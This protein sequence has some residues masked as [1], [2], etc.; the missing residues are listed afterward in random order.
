MEVWIGDDSDLKRVTGPGRKA[1]QTVALN[2]SQGKASGQVTAVRI[3]PDGGRVALVLTAA[4]SSQIYI[5]NIV[6][7][8]NQVSVNGLT[9]ISPQGVAVTDV[10]WNDQLKL[11]ATGRD[12]LA[13]GEGQVYEV[14]CDGSIWNSRGNFEL[15]GTPETVTAASGSEAVVSVGDT[16]WQQQGSTWQGLLN[17]ENVGTNPVYL[18]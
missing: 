17:G 10:A 11:F 4:G 8:N 18:E 3:S 16:L 15:P 13:G 5:G 9:P 14:Q 6:R 2:V 1:V 12:L 7:N